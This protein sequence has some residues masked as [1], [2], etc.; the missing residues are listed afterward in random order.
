MIPG[1]QVAA[2]WQLKELV[3]GLFRAERIA[4]AREVLAVIGRVG[5]DEPSVSRRLV[6]KLQ[7][8]R[9]EVLAFDITGAVTNARTE[10]ASLGFSDE[11]RRPT[12]PQFRNDRLR[13]PFACG[14]V[15]WQDQPLHVSE[16]AI[17]TRWRSAA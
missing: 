17:P 12:V 2:G 11:A 15:N 5:A 3:R 8:W 4:Q 10:S 13:P 14:G 6:R 1:G 16:G 9:D 7:P